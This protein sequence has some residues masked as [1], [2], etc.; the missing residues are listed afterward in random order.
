[1][2]SQCRFKESITSRSLHRVD[3]RRRRVVSSSICS[4]FQEIEKPES[5]RAGCGCWCRVG[6]HQ[7][8][9]G[10]DERFQPATKAHPAFAV[11]GVDTLFTKMTAAG[12][13]C[14]WDG[15]VASTR[16]FFAE[17]PWGNRLEFTEAASSDGTGE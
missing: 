14:A 8:H 10:V 15:T 9:I 5:L 3:V 17:D 6:A 7:L 4:A 13:P 2:P 12:V 16:R 1:M 11:N